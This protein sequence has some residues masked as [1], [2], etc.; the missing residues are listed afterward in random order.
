MRIVT[1]LTLCLLLALAG[2]GGEPATSSGRYAGPP[3]TPP[4]T[5]IAVMQSNNSKPIT[6]AAGQNFVIGLHRADTRN[7]TWQYSYNESLLYPLDSVLTLDPG[8]EVAGTMWFL[9]KA[10]QPGQTDVTFRMR[11]AQG[12]PTPAPT[13]EVVSVTVTGA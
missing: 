12:T 1:V 3:T 11:Y 4:W 7:F 2:C 6:V 9:F 10:V 13:P 5:D 8:S